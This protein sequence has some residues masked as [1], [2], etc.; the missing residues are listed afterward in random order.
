MKK[1]RSSNSN[2]CLDATTSSVVTVS[3]VIS[4]VVVIYVLI[5]S[6]VI[7]TQSQK[8]WSND[9]SAV[10]SAYQPVAASA[11]PSSAV[12]PSASPQSSPTPLP[13][14][15]DYLERLNAIQKNSSNVDLL[16]FLYGFLSSIL[17]GVGAYYV[18]TSKRN[19]EAAAAKVKKLTIELENCKTNIATV[20]AAQEA[21][22]EIQNSIATSNNTIRQE[23]K[24]IF[25]EQNRIQSAQEDILTKQKTIQNEQIEVAQKHSIM[26]NEVRLQNTTT[27]SLVT[28]SIIV[29]CQHL[30]LLETPES[31][32]DNRKTELLFLLIPRFNESMLRLSKAIFELN[33]SH[34]A[35]DS[36]AVIENI[37][38]LIQT[39]IKLCKDKSIVFTNDY[40]LDQLQIASDCTKRIR[41]LAR[42]LTRDSF[43]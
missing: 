8:R 25:A 19:A 28:Y 1:D 42:A 36:L 15:I 9:I 21:L 39:S 12:S 14:T 23:Q 4:I 37:F 17:V 6:I 20:Q 35:T 24:T 5:S 29:S 31:E 10:I 3:L 38:G 33:P 16:V 41:Q 43:D 2:E 13:L 32:E 22:Q 34:N 30:I 27:L 18:N 11:T 40:V 26:S 7:F